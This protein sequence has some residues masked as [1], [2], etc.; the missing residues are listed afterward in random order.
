MFAI[1][2]SFGHISIKSANEYRKLNSNHSKST[3]ITFISLT[4]K[5]YKIQQCKYRKRKAKERRWHVS[6]IE[7]I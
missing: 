5:A 1:K 2:F 6:E 7:N 4:F 3:E